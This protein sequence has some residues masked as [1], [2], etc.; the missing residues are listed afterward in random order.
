SGSV[1]AYSVIRPDRKAVRAV[2]D[3]SAGYVERPT[4]HEYPPSDRLRHPAVQTGRSARYAEPVPARQWM[5]REPH[6]PPDQSHYRT[7]IDFPVPAARHPEKRPA[8]HPDGNGHR[9]AAS[10]C[11]SGQTEPVDCGL[12]IYRYPDSASPP[13]YKAMAG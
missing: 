3:T 4:G 1:A 11:A 13:V 10:G 6:H 7:A 9:V 12:E 8:R 5:D 2:H